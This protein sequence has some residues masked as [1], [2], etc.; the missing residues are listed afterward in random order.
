MLGSMI[1]GPYSINLTLYLAFAYRD[2]VQY[3]DLDSPLLYEKLPSELDF[4]Y[5]GA[6]LSFKDQ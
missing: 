2:V 6:M 4:V 5:K 1:E 3:I